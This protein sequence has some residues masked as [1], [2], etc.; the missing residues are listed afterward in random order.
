MIYAI[1]F[2]ILVIVLVLILYPKRGM[3]NKNFVQRS[4]DF[5]EWAK[6]MHEGESITY[7]QTDARVK[8]ESNSIKIRYDFSKEMGILED[9]AIE[10]KYKILYDEGK[11]YTL[12]I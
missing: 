6:D 1:G 5:M 11:F 9:R 4:V 10:K 7:V 12:E 2:V 8:S 3:I